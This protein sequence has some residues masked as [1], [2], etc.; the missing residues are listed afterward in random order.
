MAA[1]GGIDC[2]VFTAGVGEHSAEIR[3]QICQRLNWLGIEIDEKANLQN[4]QIIS[5]SSSQ[6]SVKVIPTD[7]TAMIAKNIYFKDEA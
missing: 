6:V 7:E 5:S 3:K 2:L 1:I 4:K